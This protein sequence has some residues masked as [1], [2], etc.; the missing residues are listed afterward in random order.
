MTTTAPIPEG[1]QLPSDPKADATR[2][3]D[4][5]PDPP[6]EDA[7]EEEMAELWAGDTGNQGA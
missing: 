3:R 1:A 6:L 5:K 7:E 2:R 4:V